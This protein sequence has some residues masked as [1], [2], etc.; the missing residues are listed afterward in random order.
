MGGGAQR[1]GSAVD[2]PVG[3]TVERFWWWSRTKPLPPSRQVFPRNAD[4]QVE[5][6]SCWKTWCLITVCL[7]CTRHHPPSFSSSKG[8]GWKWGVSTSLSSLGCALTQLEII[9]FWECDF[10]CSGQTCDTHLLK[11]RR[12]QWKC[13]AVMMWTAVSV[14]NHLE[15]SCPGTCPAW[16]TSNGFI[17]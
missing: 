16:G 4:H 9:F 8:N 3:R 11:K 1:G 13:S 17:Y 12:R 7:G 6:G 2:S 10:F 5:R 14:I 15:T